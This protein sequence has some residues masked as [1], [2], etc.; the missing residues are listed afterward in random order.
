MFIITEFQENLSPKGPTLE[1]K[2]KILRKKS[3]WNESFWAKQYKTHYKSKGDLR[4]RQMETGA[5]QTGE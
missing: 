3:Q 5:R 1:K 4:H 2:K